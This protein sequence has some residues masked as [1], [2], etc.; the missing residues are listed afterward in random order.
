MEVARLRALQEK[1]QDT[2]SAEDELRAKRYQVRPQCPGSSPDLKPHYV[3][4]S[5]QPHTLFKT[6]QQHMHCASTHT[7]CTSGCAAPFPLPLLLQEAKDREYRNREQ[8]AAARQAAMIADLAAAR[9][10]QMRCKLMAQA[11][12]AEVE[13]AE[14]RRVLEVNREKQMQDMSQVR[15]VCGVPACSSHCRALSRHGQPLC[16]ATGVVV[17]SSLR[18]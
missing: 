17:C 15:R 5:L 4:C 13:Q 7:T 2:R 11:V 18:L 8:A 1:V 9:E 14:F 3:D 12:V 16:A 10:T 6:K